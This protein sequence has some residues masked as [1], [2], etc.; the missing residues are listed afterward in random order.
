VFSSVTEAGTALLAA[1]VA[2]AT[3]FANQLLLSNDMKLLQG[4]VDLSVQKMELAQQKMETAQQK[5]EQRVMSELG[6]VKRALQHKVHKPR[7]STRFTRTSSS[8]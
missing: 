3:V 1:V 7:L 6:S 8:G 2:V 5:M 4:K